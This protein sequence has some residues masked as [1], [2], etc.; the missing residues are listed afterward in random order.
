[1]GVVKIKIGKTVPL[2]YDGGSFTYSSYINFGSPHVHITNTA[3]GRDGFLSSST[4][5]A[6]NVSKINFSSYWFTYLTIN[7]EA[8]FSVNLGSYIGNY[9]SGGKKSSGYYSPNAGV[10]ETVLLNHNRG[11]VPAFI[12]LGS[13]GKVQQSASIQGY[14]DG[15]R[16]VTILCDETKVYLRENY[17]AV[18]TTIPSMTVSGKIILLSTNL[19]SA[20][21]MSTPSI[22]G[23]RVTPTRVILGQ[24][25]FDSDYNYL[26]VPTTGG[27]SS[28]KQNGLFLEFGFAESPGD[29]LNITLNNAISVY[30]D[31]VRQYYIN[32][33]GAGTLHASTWNSFISLADSLGETYRVESP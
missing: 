19:T 1:M 11:Y 30:S 18:E 32:N 7:Q 17:V 20:S 24:G 14:G 3:D 9:D 10:V 15:L 33:F 29:R 23:L 4:G 13:D 8:N 31:G 2:Q 21:S 12:V 26:Y 16:V 5:T 28:I 6:N 22:Y 25:A 27:Y